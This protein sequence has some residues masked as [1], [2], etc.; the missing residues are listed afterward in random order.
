MVDVYTEIAKKASEGKPIP[1]PDV[2]SL[3]KKAPIATLPETADLASAVEFFAGGTHRILIT[4][5]NSDEIIGIFSQWFLVNF[6]W[7]NGSSFSVVDHLY[8]K[9]L[10]DL[11]IGTHQI[12]AIK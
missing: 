4:K 12:I 5:E 9:I 1:L 8:P 6:L 3:A 10:K 11:D 7:D 2:L